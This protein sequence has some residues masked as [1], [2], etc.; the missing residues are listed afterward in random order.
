MN[1]GSESFVIVYLDDITVYSKNAKEHKHHVKQVLA[2]LYEAGLYAK[3]SKCEFSKSK[4]EFWGYVVSTDGIDMNRSRVSTIA[5]WPALTTLK[6]LEA[7]LGFI[8]F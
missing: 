3:L 7:F 4:I 6:T 2:L 5:D 1:K 8:N